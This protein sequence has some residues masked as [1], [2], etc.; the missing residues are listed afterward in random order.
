[1]VRVESAA[2]EHDVSTPFDIRYEK[3]FLFGYPGVYSID[4]PEPAYGILLRY[5][6]LIDKM[7]PRL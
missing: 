3:L 6:T 7:P 4:C 1:M 5:V 2:L